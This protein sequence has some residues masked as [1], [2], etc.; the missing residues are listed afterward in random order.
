MVPRKLQ[1]VD[2]MWSS[3]Q[4]LKTL[5]ERRVQIHAR[6]CLHYAP[7]A[8][9]IALRLSPLLA[10]TRDPINLVPT[11]WIA[12]SRQIELWTD[13]YEGTFKES[14]IRAIRDA[15]LEQIDQINS[16]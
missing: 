15:V 7:I 16:T 9:Y 14:A 12:L 8:K 6:L 2:Q 3:Y 1:T 11:A 10:G 5:K 13:P 4:A